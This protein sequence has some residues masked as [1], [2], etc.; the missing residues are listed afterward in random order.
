MASARRNSA[1]ELAHPVRYRIIAAITARAQ[2]TASQLHAAIADVAVSS[3]YR[4]LARLV[5]A[6]VLRIV[7]ERRVRGTVERTYAVADYTRLGLSE[8]AKLPRRTRR[9]VAR[10]AT[11]VMLA[12]LSAYLA[13]PGF[14]MPHDGGLLRTFALVPAAADHAALKVRLDE[15]FHDA[16]ATV[17]R[18]GRPTTFYLLSVPDGRPRSKE[19]P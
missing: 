9:A 15:V 10:T 14:D 17:L 13:S 18:G 12:Q 19:T 7:G 8:A 1:A 3:L 2:L 16:V 11:A 4:H 6:R 5:A